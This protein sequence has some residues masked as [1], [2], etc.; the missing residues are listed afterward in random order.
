[1]KPLLD[2]TKQDEEM[3]H[4]EEEM[5]KLAEL[6]SKRDADLQELERRQQQLIG[7]STPYASAFPHRMKPF[8]ICSSGE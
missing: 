1:M 4:K 2:V 3:K 8:C 7:V 6:M 5:K